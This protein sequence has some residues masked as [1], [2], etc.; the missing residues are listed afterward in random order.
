MSFPADLHADPSAPVTA[1]AARLGP[2]MR[3]DVFAADCPSR[4][5]LRHLTG[6]WGAMVVVALA[7]GPRRFSALR[8]QIAGVSERMLAQTLQELEAD[9]IVARHA[10]PVVPPH[11]EYELTAPGREVVQRLAGLV[12]WIEL[13]L[14]RLRTPPARD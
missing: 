2:E 12:D 9:G 5:V 3:G 4:Q 1:L 11:V 13:N 7:D 14:P 6:R 8:R 10:L